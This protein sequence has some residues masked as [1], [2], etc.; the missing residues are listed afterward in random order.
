MRFEIDALGLSMGVGWAVL[1]LG[2]VILGG[3]MRG[4]VGF[5]GALALVPVLSLTLGPRTAVAIAGLIGVPTIFQLLPEALRNAE[6]RFVLPAGIAIAVGAP[7]GS[8]ILTTVSPRVMTAAIGGSVMATAIATWLG[9]APALARRQWVPLLAGFI[10]GMLQGAAGVGG[11]PSVAVAMA[12]GG[13][14]RQQRANVLGLVTFI[15]G[16]G[17]V[18]HWYFG[19]FTPQ[20]IGL[21]LL[22][23][24]TYLGATWLGSRFFARGG[25]RHFRST[26][27]LL[28]LGIGFA[29]VVG[30]IRGAQ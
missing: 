9:I 6:R 8:L 22:L 15:S 26:A 2:A 21:A 23:L 20:V 19:L 30:A 11:P 10:S 14:P 1:A 18:S 29:A 12:R 5:G 28:L 16:L 13:E 4:F 24:P 17:A 25:Q 3:F 7:L 27:L